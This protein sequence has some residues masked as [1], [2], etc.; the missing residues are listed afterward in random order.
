MSA[1]NHWI[2]WYSAIGR[3][4]VCRVFAW[5]MR[6][7][8][9]R[10]AD[11]ERLRGDGDAPAVERLTRD[12]EALAFSAPNRSSSRR[13]RRSGPGPRSRGHARRASRRP[14]RDGRPRDRAA[15]ETPRCRGRARPAR[16]PQTRSRRPPSRRWRPTPCVRSSTVAVRRL[17][18]PSSA[19]SPRRCRRPPRT[20]RMR[21]SSHRRRAGAA[22]V[23]AARRCR[24]VRS[25]SA[26]SELWT[27]RMTAT[28]ALPRAMASIAS[29]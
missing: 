10:L 15:R 9:R 25:T 20:A 18:S 16:W 28:V 14:A 2:A 8:E 3:P 4:K 6:L 19:G 29:A 1:R 17:A 27:A 21:R 24:H 23:S 26:T 13:G 12:R 5:A 22:T 11:A 7:V